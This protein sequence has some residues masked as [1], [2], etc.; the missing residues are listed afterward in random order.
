M[1]NNIQRKGQDV[2]EIF[3]KLVEQSVPDV[4]L[5]VFDGNPLEYHY[6]MILFHEFVEKRVDDPRGKLTHLIKHT[7]GNDYVKERNQV[8][9]KNGDVD[10]FQKFC[11]FVVK[12][13]SITQSSQWNPLDTPNFPLTHT[14]FKTSWEPTRQMGSTCDE[15]YKKGKE[16]SNTL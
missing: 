1:F 14:T 11:N 13:E 2:T 8:L 4:D 16:G 9:A 12:C 6:F 10:S 7:K 3:C 5:D 15:S